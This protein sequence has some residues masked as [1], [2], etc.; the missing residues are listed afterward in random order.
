MAHINGLLSLPSNRET[1]YGITYGELKRR[2]NPPESLT[3]VDLV[4]YVRHSKSSGRNLLDK[5]GIVSSGNR[6]SSPT[7][8]SKMCE[9]EA[10]VLGDG[11]LKMNMDYFPGKMLSRMAAERVTERT[12]WTN[13][14]QKRE[15]KEERKNKVKEKMNQIEI[16]RWVLTSFPVPYPPLTGCELGIRQPRTRLFTRRVWYEL[17]IGYRGVSVEVFP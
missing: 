1:R 4:A 17:G 3:R 8:L 5:Y 2:C 6:T 9:N 13:E 7:V 14:E 12:K 15:E 10:R 11:I 16:T